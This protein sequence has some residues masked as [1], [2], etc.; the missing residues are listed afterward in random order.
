MFGI[1]TSGGEWW[2]KI[3]DVVRNL[4]DTNGWSFAIGFVTIVLVVAL[5]RLAPRVP[6]FLLALALATVLVSVA[7]LDT[8]HS[9][10]VVGDIDRGVP[11]PTWPGVGFDET[12]SLLAP[13]ASVALLVFASSAATGSA[14]AVR[15]KE[16]LQPAKEFV[17]LAAANFGA[18]LLQGF[19]ANASDSRSFI[20]ADGA[21]KSQRV[22]V[23]CGLIVTVTLV[24]LTP[25]F[26]NLPVAALAG[27]VLVTATKL[28]DV[29]QFRRLWNVRRTD[30]AL[31][32]VTFLGVL[33]FGVLPGIGVG[34]AVSLLEVMRRAILPHTA[35]LGLVENTPTYR[36]VETFEG[37]ELIPGLL[38]YRF[39]A[40][41]FFANADVFRSEIRDLVRNAREPVRQVL[42]SAE[43]ITDM[44]VTGGE[45]V[46]R[47]IDDLHDAGVALVMAR[48][49]TSLRMTLRRLGLEEKIGARTSTSVSP[50]LRP[51]SL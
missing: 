13:A 18:G 36:D 30:F 6:A 7:D 14:L 41:L 27:V 9:V 23:V 12:L 49:R 4:A 46:G 29:A 51:P 48:V 32:F 16:D 5:Q 2:E 8:A 34:V 44:D 42:V 28:I 50:M 10:A 20:V 35:V 40:P 33:L 19:P 24:A 25:I 22:N 43:G 11:L 45:A 26:R 15:D 39:D 37:A 1:S 38:V 47:L 3:S 31:A 21:A 17:G